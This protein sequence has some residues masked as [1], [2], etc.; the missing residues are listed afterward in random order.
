[1]IISKYSLFCIKSITKLI[2][3]VYRL[4]LH[5]NEKR[6]MKKKY[7]YIYEYVAKISITCSNM[8]DSF[9]IKKCMMMI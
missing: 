4:K 5:E 8:V 2:D 3:D 1:M 7:I 9:I 6:D